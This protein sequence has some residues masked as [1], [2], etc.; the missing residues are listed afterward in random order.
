MKDRQPKSNVIEKALD[1]LCCFVPDNRGMR[2]KEVAAKLEMH[3]AT[4]SRILRTLV[5]K[6]FLQHDPDARKFSLGPSALRTGSAVEQSLQKELVLIAKPHIDGLSMQLGENVGLEQMVGENTI[7]VY[8]SE[9]RRR[10]QIAR[11]VGDHTP[12]NAAAGAKAILAYSDADRV[13]RFISK[14]SRFEALTPNTITH[15][16]ELFR[17][18]REIRLKGFSV[19]MEEMDVGINAIGAPIFNHENIPVAAAVIAGPSHRVSPVENS[20]MV[21]LLKQT[22]KKISSLLMQP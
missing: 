19:D 22:A 12:I 8:E 4:A 10:L 18:F 17:Q 20:E 11:A 13:K 7:M 3:R 2:T 21:Y 9:G 6:G 16:N 14:N 15:P 1:V 5:R